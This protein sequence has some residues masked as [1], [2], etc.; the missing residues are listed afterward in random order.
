HLGS[1]TLSQDAVRDSTACAG[2]F[3][4]VAFSHGSGGHRRQ[5][6]FLCTHLASHGYVVAAVDHAGNTAADTLLGATAAEVDAWIAARPADIRWLLDRILDGATSELGH[7]VDADRIGV[8]GHSFGGW[9]VLEATARDPR[10]RAVVAMAPGGIDDPPK[11]VLR[12]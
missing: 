8:V 9:T 10:I 6:T 2:S 11:G 7:I 5:S 4:L 3:P 1:V 12:L